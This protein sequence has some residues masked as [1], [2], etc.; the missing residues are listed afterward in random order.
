MPR[1]TIKRPR[2]VTNYEREMLMDCFLDI[3][4]ESTKQVIEDQKTRS[5]GST[6]TSRKLNAN[7]INDTAIP[8]KL[9]TP[10]RAGEVDQSSANLFKRP[11]I[12][13]GGSNTSLERERPTS[14]N[15]SFASLRNPSVA[16]SFLSS[17]PPSV[18]ENHDSQNHLTLTQET[19]PDDNAPNSSNYDSTPTGSFDHPVDAATFSFEVTTSFTEVFADP[20]ATRLQEN[21]CT[22]FRK[23]P[24]IPKIYLPLCLLIFFKQSVTSPTCLSFLFT[25]NTKSYE[26]FYTPG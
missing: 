10:K 17:R 1:P 19:I 8:I 5:R 23:S 25:S 7:E 3:A 22:V 6:R 4:D 20:S 2:P 12:P 24:Y 15:T 18:F 14:N 9:P 13:E 11:R 16:E 21:L 26:C